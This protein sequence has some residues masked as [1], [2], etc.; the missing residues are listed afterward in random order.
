MENQKY[1]YA[2]KAFCNMENTPLLH[3]KTNDPLA[4]LFTDITKRVNYFCQTKFLILIQ[5]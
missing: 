4:K 3:Q 5:T 1:I 2:F